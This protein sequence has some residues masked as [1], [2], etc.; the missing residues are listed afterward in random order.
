MNPVK[1]HHR[2]IVRALIWFVVTVSA[3]AIGTS[4]LVSNIS[5]ANRAVSV[6]LESYHLASLNRTR[7]ISQDAVALQARLAALDP[8]ASQPALRA[9]ITGDV[10]ELR[11]GVAA[12][13]ALHE[14]HGEADLT[15]ATARLQDRFTAFELE[16]GDFQLV[17]LAGRLDSFRL[18]LTQLEKLH[19]MRAEEL[20][21]QLKTARER[22]SL[23]LA[24]G[25]SGVVLLSI[26]V[27]VYA[28]RLLRKAMQH[29]AATESALA[30]TEQHLR[31]SEKLHA[32]GQLVGG[33]AHDFN[34][35][36]MIINGHIECALTDEKLTEPSRADLQE[37]RS[38]GNRAADLTRQLLTF[39]RQQPVE[40]SLMD[41]NSMVRSTETMLR[42]FIADDVEMVISLEEAPMVVEVDPG[43]LQ[44]VLTNLILNAKDAI[45]G[46]GRISVS[47]ARIDVTAHDNIPDIVPGPYCR[48]SV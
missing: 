48:L 14:Q 26:L 4:F 13:S 1:Y 15:P 19:I 10:N 11:K 44:Q 6:T 46:N 47:T 30:N 18:A 33:I 36:L 35:L 5:S 31:N 29:H 39:S 9:T 38:A 34:N 20:V 27:V 28:F 45:T 16:A 24:I 37:V 23:I 41:L 12:L 2:R 3:A 21:G 32:L 43:Q 17:A 42:S 40:P 25:V 22:Q 7:R 8:S